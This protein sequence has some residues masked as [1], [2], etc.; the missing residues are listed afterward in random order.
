MSTGKREEEELL[1]RIA[2]QRW[3]SRGTP[4]GDAWSDWFAAKEA[5]RDETRALTPALAILIPVATYFV[6]W[7]AIGWIGNQSLSLCIEESLSETL[8]FVLAA[9]LAQC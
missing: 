2:R 6:A 5:L 8:R 9:E 4:E 3:E 7:M 1:S